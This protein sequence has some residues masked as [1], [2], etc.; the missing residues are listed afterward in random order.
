MEKRKFDRTRLRIVDTS[1]RSAPLPDEHA[2]PALVRPDARGPMEYEEG[3]PREERL[4]MEEAR[5]LPGPFPYPWQRVAGRELEERPFREAVLENDFLAASFLLDFG[6]RLRSLF[7]KTSGRELLHVNPVFQPANLALRR[8][9]FSGGVEWNHGIRGHSPF[10]CAPVFAARLDTPQGDALRLYEWERR[11]GGIFQ[12]DFHLPGDLPVLLVQVRLRNPGDRAIPMYWWSNIAVPETPH[13]RILAPASDAICG[14]VG[15]PFRMVDLDAADE[16][17]FSRPGR[18]PHAAELF[19]RVPARNRPWVVA[20]EPEGGLF[21]VSTGLLNGRKLFAWGRHRG[22][23]RWQEYLANENTSGYCEIQAG[24]ARTQKELLPMP[25]GAEWTWLEAY[26]AIGEGMTRGSWPEAIARAEKRIEH[27]VPDSWLNARADEGASIARRRPAELIHTGSGWGALE[28]RLRRRLKVPPMSDETT[29]FPDDSVG[30]QQ[31]HWAALLAGEPPSPEPP[32]TAA[33]GIC[34]R[35]WRVLLESAAHRNPDNWWV[36]YQLGLLHYAESDVAGAEASWRRS[37]SCRQTVPALRNL[38]W[39][40]EWRDARAEAAD[41]WAAAVGEP[42]PHPHLLEEAAEA[43][44]RLDRS[45]CAEEA[46]HLLAKKAPQSPRLPMLR[47]LLAVENRDHAE[48]RRLIEDEEFPDIR[49]G[50]NTL[51]DKWIEINR[52]RAEQTPD[53]VLRIC[54]LPFR[55]DFRMFP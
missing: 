16:P 31:A 39:T 7:D 14:G 15:D 27:L 35:G 44:L 36:H 55:A 26:G 54:P 47:L 51:T 10:T 25:A 4:R 23:R 1:I 20:A 34:G 3:F 5:D 21:Q 33:H 38:A 52:S 43:F 9:W 13:T 2:F 45:D 48:V 40:T 17:D 30:G 24:L 29:P 49:E 32:E 22:G 11:H 53:E 18:Y 12:V 46:L 8:A 6:G 28:Q 42:E 37:L 19:F 50:E 41:L